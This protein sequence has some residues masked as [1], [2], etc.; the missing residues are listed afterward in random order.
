[1]RKGLL[2]TGGALLLVFYSIAVVSVSSLEDLKGEANWMYLPVFGPA[3]HMASFGSQCS[4]GLGC[5]TILVVDFLVA[6]GQLTGAILLT[7]GA[8]VRKNVYV[9]EETATSRRP[10]GNGHAGDW[11]IRLLG[12]RL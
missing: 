10:S 1:M 4:S 6:A 11:T 5:S 7:V 2:I 3:F 8:L 9:L 12:V